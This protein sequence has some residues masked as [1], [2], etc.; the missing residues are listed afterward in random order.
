MHLGRPDISTQLITH[1]GEQRIL[2][3]MPN[4]QDLIAKVKAIPGRKYSKTYKSWH[5][6]NTKA[7]SV[8]IAAAFASEHK[9]YTKLSQENISNMVSPIVFWE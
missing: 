2:V 6:P 7:S 5:L 4:R 9:I 1:R 3:K 8:A